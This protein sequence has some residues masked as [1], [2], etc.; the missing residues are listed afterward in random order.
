MDICASIGGRVRFHRRREPSTQR[1]QGYDPTADRKEGCVDKE[2]VAS[3]VRECHEIRFCT[4]HS[5]QLRGVRS[6]HEVTAAL[7]DYGGAPMAER[8]KQTSG[9][10][11]A[12]GSV[13]SLPGARYPLAT[14]AEGG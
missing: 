9:V 4:L 12:I 5:L 8:I 3:P 2:K 13:E 1:V 14:A 10:P 7:A 11:P 6:L